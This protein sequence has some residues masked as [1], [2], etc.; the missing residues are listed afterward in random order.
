M[1]L[2]HVDIDDAVGLH[3]LFDDGHERLG[4]DVGTDGR[5]TLRTRFSSPNTATLPPAPHSRLPLRP[6]PR[7]GSK[8]E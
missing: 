4:A 6:P 3:L 8:A 5:I 1:G 7:N 2:E